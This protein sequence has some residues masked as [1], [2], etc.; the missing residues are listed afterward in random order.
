MAGLAP[1]NWLDW[2]I[3]ISSV[4]GVVSGFRRGL[5]LSVV[6][7]VAAAAAIGLAIH[8]APTAAAAGNMQWH[9]D[10]RLAD[11]LGRA[12]PLPDGAGQTPYSPLSAQI[13][14]Q[15]LAQSTTPVYAHAVAAIL[16]GPPG[17]AGPT[18]A[19]LGDYMDQAVAA[20]IT[21]ALAFGAVLVVA[22]ALFLLVGGMLV[23]AFAPHG[24]AAAVDALLGAGA[25]GLGRL[26]NVTALLA[27]LASVSAMPVFAGLTG[28]IH[29]SH[30]APLLLE[31]LRGVLP[32]VGR[33]MAP[34]L[35]WN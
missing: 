16:G 6:G 15:Q 30:W 2:F 22:E 23:H 33:W 34:W 5:L 29:S 28:A 27:L 10:A 8:F 35:S 11:F 20:R 21:T 7:L 12:M 17:I 9:L 13:L 14:G 4:L 18:P 24:S 3:L 19:T 25:G 31:G 1:G 26:V 32:V